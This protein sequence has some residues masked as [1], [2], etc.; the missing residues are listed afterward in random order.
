MEFVFFAAIYSW[1]RTEYIIELRPKLIK[2]F[3][4][5][6]FVDIGD[7]NMFCSF[8]GQQF[9]VLLPHCLFGQKGCC[10]QGEA[11]SLF[12]QIKF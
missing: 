9:C 6:F 3:L 11:F 10:E 1:L 7:S 2:M 5:F 8:D 12:C 4:R